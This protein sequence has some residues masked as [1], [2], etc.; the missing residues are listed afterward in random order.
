MGREDYRRRRNILNKSNKQQSVTDNT[1]AASPR[2]L[3]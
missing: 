3:W 1:R 2:Y